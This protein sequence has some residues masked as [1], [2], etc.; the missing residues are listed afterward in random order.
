MGQQETYFEP[1]GDSLIS[2]LDGAW[3]VPN[4]PRAWKSLWAQPMVLQCDVWQVKP[5]FDPFEDIVNLGAR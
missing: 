5:R 2:V 3:F 4:I 1:F